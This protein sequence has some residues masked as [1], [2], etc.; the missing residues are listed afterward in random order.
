MLGKILCFSKRQAVSDWLKLAPRMDSPRDTSSYL[1]SFTTAVL[2]CTASSVC[3]IILRGALTGTLLVWR[4]LIL[5][6]LELKGHA[7]KSRNS[8]STIKVSGHDVSLTAVNDN[9]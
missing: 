8:Q 2:L 5:W 4:A 1:Q 3:A 9:K 7:H 6:F